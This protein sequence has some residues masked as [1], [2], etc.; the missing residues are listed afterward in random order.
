MTNGA[1]FKI[2]KKI[3][4]HAEILEEFGIFF[5]HPGRLDWLRRLPGRTIFL[6]EIVQYWTET[7][8]ELTDR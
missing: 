6:F 7:R 3:P 8:P 1:R 4:L 5:Q 2:C